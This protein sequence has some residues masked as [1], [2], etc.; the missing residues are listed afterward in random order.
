ME[1]LLRPGV[2]FGGAI[3]GEH[4]IGR[5]KEPWF[6]ALTDPVN[7]RLMRGIKPTFDPTGI[8]NPGA[9]FDLEDLA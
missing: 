2:E 9:T 8:L 3:G 1:A 4:G 5:H 6:V 7:V